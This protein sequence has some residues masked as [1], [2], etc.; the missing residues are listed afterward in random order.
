MIDHRKRNYV[1]SKYVQ[2]TKIENIEKRSRSNY[3]K[4][5]G[6]ILNGDIDMDYGEYMRIRM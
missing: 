6:H 1:P 2:V 5:R 3:R 4:Y